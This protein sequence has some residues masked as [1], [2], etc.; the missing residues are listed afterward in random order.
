VDGNKGSDYMILVVD[1]GNSDIVLGVY[2]NKGQLLAVSRTPSLRYKSVDEYVATIKELLFLKGIKFQDI[3]DS[4]LS[5][6]VPQLTAVLTT[7]I[8]AVIGKKPTLLAPGIK[9]GLAIHADNPLEVGG[10]L[11]A[12]CVGTIKKYGSPAILI[13]LGTATKICMIDKKGDF[14]GC[15]ITPGVKV[16]TSA[17][18]K[19][20]SQLPNIGYVAPKHVIG[21]NTVDSMNSGIVYGHASM[22]DGFIKRFEEEVGYQAQVV[23]TGGLA[24]TIIPACQTPNIIVD[25]TII[26]DGLY[27][28]YLRESKE[29]QKK[30]GKKHA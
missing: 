27:E 5:S 4:I 3:T 24:G 21:K 18:V 17:L 29:K 20:A 11:I 12:D 8:K 30:E 16:A 9:T 6:V 28:I 26:L 22:L 19:T 25:K 14:A 7:A 10:D 1:M 2:D 23:A 15:I 13:D